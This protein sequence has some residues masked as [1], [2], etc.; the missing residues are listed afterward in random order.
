MNEAIRGWIRAHEKE[1]VDSLCGLVKLPAVSP[2]D[3]GLGELAKAE[4]LTD[5]AK[6]L[7]LPTAERYDAPDPAAQ[8][9]VR[10]NLVI[11]IPGRTS[12]R[13][14]F[15]THLDVVPEG[16]RSLW[17]FDPFTP[18]V[19][20]GKVFGRGSNDNGQEMIA[21]LY[22]AAAYIQLGIVPETC[23][24]LA[25]VADE[26]LGSAFGISCLLKQ[27][28]FR[29]D[30][31]VVVPDGGNDKGDFVEV[32]EKSVLWIEF[33]V[34]GKQV[35]AS[36][37][38][39]GINACRAANLF[40]AELDEA[41]HKAFPELDG[42]FE[43]PCSTFEPTR[44][45]P[46][47][48][49]VNTIPGKEV[50][51]FDCRVLP[52]VPLEEVESVMAEIAKRVSSMAGVKIGSVN[53][54]RAMAAPATSIDA[55]VVAKLGKSIRQVYGF[56]PRIGGVGGGTCAAHFRMAGIP[57]VVWAQEADTA[58][59]PNEFAEIGHMVNEALVFAGML[60]PEKAPEV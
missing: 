47:V 12:A 10:P 43:P 23:I 5:L 35:H 22:A 17:E 40:S 33:T 34:E 27:G 57:A 55:P 41:L 52:S 38:D 3:G 36:R 49:N 53:I 51:S 48:A 9:G 37:P 15:V 8:G 31:L 32:A 26:E 18:F 39:L 14:W 6:E 45:L 56:A 19:R 59:M 29:P 58:H 20:D 1:M 4:W 46:N 28:L 60:Q 25:F 7:G 30:D 2:K 44:R 42:L 54:Q 50:L 11:T 13:T 24:G 16:D 21:S